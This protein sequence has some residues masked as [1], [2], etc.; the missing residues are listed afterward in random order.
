VRRSSHDLAPRAIA[1]GPLA[2]RVMFGV[3]IA[4]LVG[5]VLVWLL[6]DNGSDSAA[7]SAPARPPAPLS[8]GVPSATSIQIP[9]PPA[10]AERATLP[11]RAV[12]QRP[13]TAERPIVPATFHA[14][15]PPSPTAL[16]P[17]A[18]ASSTPPPIPRPR[19]PREP[20]PE[21]VR[22]T[23][24]DEAAGGATPGQEPDKTPSVAEAVAPPDRPA[25]ARKKG[26]SAG[27]K[28][29]DTPARDKSRGVI[30]DADETLPPSEE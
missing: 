14:P 8:T 28:G 2:S 20:R 16:T 15:K 21:I 30:G 27:A 5:A 9:A 26:E 12:E 10:A 1:R 6:Q 19:R 13:L 17:A 24:A 7:A 18:E 23:G 22:S 29:S 4:A 25:P 11:V 3:G